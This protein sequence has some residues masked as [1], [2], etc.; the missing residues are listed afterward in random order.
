M[1]VKILKIINY[2]CFQDVVIELDKKLNIFVGENDSGKSTI[3]EALSM[4]LTG[5]LNGSRIEHCFNLNWFNIDVR[6]KFKKD[7]SAGARPSPPFIEIEA[8]LHKLDCP[9]IAR[10]KG[11]NNSFREDVEGVKIKIKFDEQYAEIYQTLLEEKRVVDIPIEYYRVEFKPFSGDS[12]IPLTF[13][14]AKRV[15]C[16]DIMQRNYNPILNRFVSGTIDEYLSEMD[17]VELRHA[18]R[19]NRH[20][21]TENQVVK[22]LNEKLKQRSDFKGKALSFNLKEKGVDDWREH[23]AITLD[24]IPLGYLGVGTQNMFKVEMFLSAHS[25]VDMLIMEEPENNL[26]Y[27]NMSILISKL[28]INDES[29]NDT[30]QVFLSTHSSF[31]A[32][33]LGLQHIYLVANKEVKS[34]SAMKKETHD[35]FTK[36][37]GYNTLRVLLAPKVIL[38]EGSADELIVQKAYHDRFGKLPIEDGID[39][40]SIGGIAFEH[41][42]ELANLIKKPLVIVTDND[43]DVANVQARYGK[44]QDVTL[45]V[46]LDNK[47]TTLE[48]SILN[49]NNKT[50]EGFKTIVYKR[51]DGSAKNKDEILEFMKKNKTEWALRVFENKGEIN[52]PDYIV[53]AITAVKNPE[54]TNE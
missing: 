23:L 39:V 31:V 33:K 54:E 16:I 9:E 17:I 35:Y 19:S 13:I 14:M 22:E 36:L 12:A 10:L 46:E 21:F 29:C 40:I 41:Y 11:A 4:V 45:C 25:T 50:F 6:R 42:C 7:V 1:K 51:N 44:Y 20:E 53:K 30:K 49:A 28:S 38:V 26:S 5:K 32:N 8:Y 47:L 15:A 2:K 3:L 37:P 27:A 24:E 48:P 18:Y 43:G 52:Y 34:F